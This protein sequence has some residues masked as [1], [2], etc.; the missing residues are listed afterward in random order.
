MKISLIV[1]V[2]NEESNIRSLLSNLILLNYDKSQYE[3]IIQDDCSK[4]KTYEIAKAYE[5]TYKLPIIKV[6]KN[7]KN[8]GIANNRNIGAK[9]SIGEIMIHLDADAFYPYNTL[10]IVEN[11]F[12]RYNLVALSGILMPRLDNNPLLLDYLLFSLAAPAW[13]DLGGTGNLFCVKSDV[14]Y[15]IG[16]FREPMGIKGREDL[17]L[18][19]RIENKYKDRMKID[20]ML[21]T[22]ISLRRVRNSKSNKIDDV[23]NDYLKIING[24]WLNKGY[25]R[26]D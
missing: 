2:Y 14:F 22:F 6:F 5:Q 24:Y 9:N 12:V 13:H 1:P 19:Y 8:L 10:K 18:W 26:V 20:N 23:L 16:G 21:I 25:G 11:D 15:E 3:I 4:D 17:D 7:L